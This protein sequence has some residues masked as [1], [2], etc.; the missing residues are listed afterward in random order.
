MEAEQAPK[1]DLSAGGGRLVYDKE[2]RTIVSQPLEKSPSY[3]LG[4]AEATLKIAAERLEEGRDPKEVAA[5]LR[6]TL[7]KIEAAQ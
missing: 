3:W 4:R 6:E 2:R 7:S 5:M 1:I